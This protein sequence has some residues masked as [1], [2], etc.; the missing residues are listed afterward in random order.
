[1]IALLFLAFAW[2]LL[3]ISRARRTAEALSVEN[4]RLLELS[5]VEALSDSLTG[6]GNRRAL[7][8]DLARAAGEQTLLVLFDLDGFKHYNDSFGHPAGDALLTR[9]GDRL[10]ATLAGIGTAYRMGGDEFCILAPVEEGSADA[11]VRLAAAALHEEGEGFR[12]GCSFGAAHLP[13]DTSDPD[14]ALLLADQRMYE[15]K[16]S[17]RLS[18]GRQSAN[19]L[20]QLLAERSRCL[21]DHASGVAGL[22]EATAAELGLGTGEV[23]RI[24]LAAEL[25]DIGKAAIPDAILEKPGPLDA[26]ELDFVRRHSTIGER[27]V[28]AAPSLAHAADLVR[29]HHERFDGGG[30]PDGLSGEQIPVGARIIA[31]ANAFDVMLRE[32]PYRPAVS[33]SE[34]LDT[35]TAEAGAAFDPAV[36]DACHA[37]VSR[38]PIA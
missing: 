8:L 14:A 6:L 23:E 35:L 17:G 25:H 29:A 33:A 30:Y 37:V 4:R 3:R 2:V 28:R 24:R 9:L 34:A 19:V 12:I 5:Q 16:I 21:G 10:S 18:P 15:Q 26:R 11:I 38:R 36:V 20:V 7:R 13:L 22:A 32:R 31:V 27:I 1:V